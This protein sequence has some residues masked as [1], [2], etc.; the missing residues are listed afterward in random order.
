MLGGGGWGHS[1]QDP[2]AQFK[3]DNQHFAWM[4]GTCGSAHEV[5]AM[6]EEDSETFS[7]FQAAVEAGE[8]VR[9]LEIAEAAAGLFDVVPDR[10]AVQLLDC[11]GR[12]AAHFALEETAFAARLR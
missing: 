11:S 8:H 7:Q 10:S 9:A 5:C 12:I 1:F 4:A 3:A 6:T 2:G